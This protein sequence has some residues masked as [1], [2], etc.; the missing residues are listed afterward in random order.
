MY[1]ENKTYSTPFYVNK[2]NEQ[3]VNI[4]KEKSKD[5]KCNE[6]LIDGMKNIKMKLN[7]IEKNKKI[8]K[9]KSITDLNY[10]KNIFKNNNVK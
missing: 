6:I 7:S 1:D 9:A 8:K 10:I 5:R 2:Q 4:K 3:K